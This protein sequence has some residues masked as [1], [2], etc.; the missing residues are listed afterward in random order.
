M[1]R[2]KKG[3]GR[4]KGKTNWAMLSV[5]GLK[6]EFY[7]VEEAS[8]IFGVT[9]D[10]VC[11]WIKKGLLE[12][13]PGDKAK[14]I[15]ITRESMLAQAA[16]LRSGGKVAKEKEKKSRISPN[17]WYPFIWWM[18]YRIVLNNDNYNESNK[19]LIKWGFPRPQHSE[20]EEL[21][22][23]L[24]EKAPID[25]QIQYK[26]R[27]IPRIQTKESFVRWIRKLNISDLYYSPEI[28]DTPII[29]HLEIRMHVDLLIKTGVPIDE[30]AEEIYEK[31]GVMLSDIEIEAYQKYLCNFSYATEEQYSEYI[32]KLPLQIERKVKLQ[33]CNQ[34]IEVIRFHLGDYGS[35]APNQDEYIAYAAYIAIKQEINESGMDYVDADR[36]AKLTKIR[37]D[38]LKNY[39]MIGGNID[40][41]ALE[42]LN[43]GGKN[44]Y[45][46]NDVHESIEDL[47][48]KSSVESQKNSQEDLSS[49]D[50]DKEQDIKSA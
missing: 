16:N 15:L 5:D 26:N 4:R 38:S 37:T 40:S 29:S 20:W 33:L 46:E 42:F 24:L 25:I 21:R 45:I 36:I 8:G 13:M 50:T 43:I 35:V 39:H 32:D 7:T 48:N 44:K 17:F 10:A 9:T 18:V 27:S 41:D 1:K 14:R 31:E 34:D 49:G 12:K 30:I 11:K 2:T 23:K 6:D 47:E 28:L 22:K 19:L 3:S